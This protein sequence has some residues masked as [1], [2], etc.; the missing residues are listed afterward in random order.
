M[1][2]FISLPSGK[3]DPLRPDLLV[4]VAAGNGSLLVEILTCNSHMRGT[5]PETRRLIEAAKSGPLRPGMR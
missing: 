3:C 4:D 2:A 1:A 5:L